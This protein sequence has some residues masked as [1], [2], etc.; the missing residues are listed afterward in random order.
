MSSG[1]LPRSDPP[2]RLPP[3]SP[4]PVRLLLARAAAAG[5]RVAHHLGEMLL[6]LL[7]VHTERVHQLRGQ[8]LA[9]ARVHLL[10]AR[11]EALLELTDRQVADDVGELVDVTRLDLLAVVLEAAVPVLR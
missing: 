6:G 11:R 9:G 5:V 8:D 3:G 7:L 2:R 4:V 10:L 1:H